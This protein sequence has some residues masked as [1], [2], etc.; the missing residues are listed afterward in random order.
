MRSH[1][2]AAHQYFSTQSLNIADVNSVE[3]LSSSDFGKLVNL[4]V[5]HRDPFLRGMADS[6]TQDIFALLQ[7]KTYPVSYSFESLEPSV[8]KKM[9]FDGESLISACQ[10]T[11]L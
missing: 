4:L 10:S 5:Q 7:Q 1:L 8:L 9:V 2:A 3:R 6:L 11:N